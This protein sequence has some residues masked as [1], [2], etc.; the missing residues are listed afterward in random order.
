MYRSIRIEAGDPSAPGLRPRVALACDGIRDH[1]DCA[2]GI[3]TQEGPWAGIKR[4]ATKIG[5]DHQFGSIDLCISFLFGHRRRDVE[6]FQAGVSRRGSL[7]VLLA[8]RSRRPTSPHRFWFKFSKKLVASLGLAGV[9]DLLSILA[10]ARIRSRV[11]SRI[12]KSWRK[13]CR[14]FGVVAAPNLRL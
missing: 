2:L 6:R 5:C 14:S 7:H 12:S 11:W 9:G 13:A 8:R 4:P 1:T 3:P 10:S